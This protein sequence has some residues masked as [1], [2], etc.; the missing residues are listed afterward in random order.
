ALWMEVWSSAMGPE[1]VLP[2]SEDDLGGDERPGALL[3][4]AEGHS[5]PPEQPGEDGEEEGDAPPLTEQLQQVQ[6]RIQ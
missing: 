6:H 3:P 1:R 2:N 5:L 4:E